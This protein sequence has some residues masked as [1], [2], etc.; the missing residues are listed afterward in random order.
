MGDSGLLDKY[1]D[2]YHAVKLNNS[3][4]NLFLLKEVYDF[5][6]EDLSLFLLGQ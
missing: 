6:P 5:M 3:F 2:I 4:P 1:L